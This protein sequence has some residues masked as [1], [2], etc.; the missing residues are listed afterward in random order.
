MPNSRIHRSNETRLFR[1]HLSCE[2]QVNL[3]SPRDGKEIVKSASA[4]RIQAILRTTTVRGCA[5]R[6]CHVHEERCVGIAPASHHG[7]RDFRAT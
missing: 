3:L 6:S 2:D 4:C 7:I 1:V 5:L